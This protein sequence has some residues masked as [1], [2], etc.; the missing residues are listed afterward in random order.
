MDSDNVDPIDEL[1]VSSEVVEGANRRLLVDLIKPHV[2]IDPETGSIHF[3]K[4]PPDLSAK[5][6]ILVYLMAKLAL[7]SRKPSY[8]PAAG[9][10]EIQESTRLPGGTVRPRLRGFLEEHVI[11]QGEEGYFFEALGL[12]AAKALLSDE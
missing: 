9:P 3:L 8:S 7:A 12:V 1:I 6:H 4:Y 10:K 11:S 2:R 5:Q